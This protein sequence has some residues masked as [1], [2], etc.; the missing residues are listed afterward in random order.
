MKLRT[1]VD[2]STNC[3]GFRRNGECTRARINSG[4][5]AENVMSTRKPKLPLLYVEEQPT[6]WLRAVT[7]MPDRNAAALCKRQWRDAAVAQASGV[8]GRLH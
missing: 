7:A 6:L 3:R 4:Q 8:Y 1:P 2:K 5:I